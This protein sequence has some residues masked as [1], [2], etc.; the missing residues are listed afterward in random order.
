MQKLGYH[1]KKKSHK[2]LCDHFKKQTGVLYKLLNELGDC[3]SHLK[4]L[5]ESADYKRDK[6]NDG[7]LQD[8]REKLGRLQGKLSLLSPV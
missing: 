6:V 3:L 1:P 8:F 4:E 5:R 7:T 2:G